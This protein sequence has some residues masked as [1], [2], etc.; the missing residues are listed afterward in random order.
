MITKTH[1][2]YNIYKKV[3]DGTRISEKDARSLYNST[4]IL[5]IGCIANIIRER[6]SGKKTYYIVNRHINYSNVCKNSCRFCAFSRQEGSPGGFT[7]NL[8]DILKKLRKS[9]SG[10]RI[11]ELHIVG[12]LHPDLPFEY[13][14]DMLKALHAKYPHVHL[15]AFTAVEIAHMAERSGFSIKE[16]LLRLKDAGLGSIPGG[17]AEVFSDRLRRAVCPDKLGGEEWLDI[18]RIAHSLDIRSNATMLYGHVETINERIDHLIRL[19]QL[20]DKT[21]GFM[22][23]IPLPYHPENTKLGGSGPTGLD[24]LK[25]TA[26]SRIF[27]DNF[28]HIKSFWIMLGVKLAQVSLDFG[29]DD[30][31][32]T[33]VEEKI[34]HAAGAST[35]EFLSVDEIRRLILE[36]NKVPVER[37]TLYKVVKRK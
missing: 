33:V 28:D 9:A 29:A 36:A 21:G 26:I 27:L 2:L 3:K 25:T 24:S 13:Y 7:L 19:R 14:T 16:T 22:S 23:F 18:H 8:K 35:P 4:D 31:D 6:K 15:Q 20:Q 10:G 32:G 12:G 1:K 17:G 5:A 11:S 30:L 37:D 34:T